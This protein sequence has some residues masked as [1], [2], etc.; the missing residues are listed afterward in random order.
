[1]K[2]KVNSLNEKQRKTWEIIREALNYK[3]TDED[4]NEFKEEA[5]G[6]LADDEED[7]YV[8]YNSMNGIKAS[9]VIDLIYA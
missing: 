7:F 6:L 3:D 9:D 1:M 5:E 8:T 4:F 2:T